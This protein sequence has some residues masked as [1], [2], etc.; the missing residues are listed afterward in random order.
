MKQK[1]ITNIDNNLLIY[2]NNSIIKDHNS[3]NDLFY[4][5]FIY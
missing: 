3:I 5:I 2:Y 4:F 1:Y